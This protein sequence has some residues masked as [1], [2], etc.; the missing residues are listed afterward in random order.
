MQKERIGFGAH[1]S[2][3]RLSVVLGWGGGSGSVLFFLVS[4]LPL[5]DACCH[6]IL[7]FSFFVLSPA[8]TMSNVGQLFKPRSNAEGE[9]E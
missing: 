1:F 9:S 5:N 2:L 4:L 7:S 6:L 3:H 8:L